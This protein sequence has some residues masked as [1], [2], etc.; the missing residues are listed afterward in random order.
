[1]RIAGDKA[2]NTPAGYWQ[3]N[4]QEETGILSRSKYKNKRV[5]VDNLVFDSLKEAN[6]YKGVMLAC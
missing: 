5:S 2:K 6:R 4:Q 3:E 1:M